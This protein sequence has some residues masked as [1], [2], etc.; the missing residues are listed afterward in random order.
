M[1]LLPWLLV[2]VSVPLLNH[3]GGATEPGTE[4]GNPPGIEARRLHIVLRDSGVEVV[5]DAGAVSPGA[6]VSVT[7]R[8]SGQQASAT[9]RADG[10]VSV[11]VP[12]SLDD[13]Y[14]VTVSNGG[15][16]QTVRVSAATNGD[17]NGAGG[18]DLGSA[19]CEALENT[20]GQRIAD[21]FSS[22]N[23]ACSV[24]DDCVFQGWGAGCYFQCGGS[25]L[26]VEGAALAQMAVEEDVA[27]V[28]TELASRCTR[29]PASSCPPPTTTTPE[30]AN[31]VCQGLELGAFSCEELS[32]SASARVADL[33]AAA[34]RSCS[35]DSD[36]TLYEPNVLCGVSCGYA[37]VVATL[38]LPELADRID[39]LEDQFCNEFTNRSCPGPLQPPCPAPLRTPRVSC[40]SGGCALSSALE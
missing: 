22:A 38:A 15:G 33:L 7:N 3:C 8:S 16:S 14:D 40:V 6:N 39:R 11:V 28:C 25:F 23:T 26:S 5:G 20:L 2:A 10:S 13:E 36:C 29:Q 30:C 35:E 21:G 27:P 24:D 34:G 37:S 4:T 19:S 18:S 1:R 32:N 17:M 9:A 31:G 12:G